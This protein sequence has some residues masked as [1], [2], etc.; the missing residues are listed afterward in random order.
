MCVKFS[1][2]QGK[3]ATETKALHLAFN[4]ETMSIIQQI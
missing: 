2:E 3:T 1:Y 4:E